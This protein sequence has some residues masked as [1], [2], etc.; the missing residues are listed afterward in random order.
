[1]GLLEIVRGVL[2]E[3]DAGGVE[4]VEVGVSITAAYLYGCVSIRH[5]R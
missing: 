1:M 5:E 3:L 4:D 2:R